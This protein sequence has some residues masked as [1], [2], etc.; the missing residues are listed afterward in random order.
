MR[1]RLALLAVAAAAVGLAPAG[2]A[3]AAP[4]PFGHG[5]TAQHGVR[6][7]P[8]SADAQRVPSFDGVPLDVDVT[9][10]AT[11]AGPWPTLVMLHGFPGD[12]ST[13]EASD[14]QGDRP[15]GAPSGQPQRYHRND[16]FYAQRGYAVV[17]YSARGFGRSCGVPDSRTS[18][19]CDRGWFHLA[20]ERWEARDAQELLTKLVDEGI[21]DR[22]RIG[23]T[24]VSYGG[25]SSLELAYLKDRIR[26]LWPG[27]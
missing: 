23:A 1:R 17:T 4:A 14:A 19:G 5:C 2:D 10:P 13:Y 24:G 15:D 18:P 9:L 27:S 8:T 26:K 20:D 22:K 12:K 21:A 16:V 7:C 6:F 11:G 3:A 25:G